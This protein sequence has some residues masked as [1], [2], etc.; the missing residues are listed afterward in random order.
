[1]NISARNML[2]GKV[3]AITPGAVNSEVILALAEK[4]EIV[5]VITNESVT[6][7][8]LK[9]GSEAYAIIKAPLIILAKGKPD[10][11]FSTRNMLEG[12]V[13]RVELGTV[14]A[15]VSLELSGGVMLHA[16]ITK[17]S[18]QGMELKAGDTATALFKAST[19][20]L[21]VRT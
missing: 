18:V 2:S 15:E 1:M 20:I 21:A 16:V 11:K 14:N 13:K 7:L 17:A 6:H 5:A 3:A 9:V 8:G 12:T 10:M 4:Q 19:V